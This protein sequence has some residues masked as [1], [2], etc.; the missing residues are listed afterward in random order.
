MGAEVAVPVDEHPDAL[1]ADVHNAQVLVSRGRLC[2]EGRQIAEG[3]LLRQGQLQLV[4]RPVEHGPVIL[5]GLFQGGAGEEPQ[6]GRLAGF[7]L[8]RALDRIVKV[9]AALLLV[10]VVLELEGQIVVQLGVGHRRHG[11][12]PAEHQAVRQDHR[13]VLL[14]GP[15]S[16][17]LLFQ[18]IRQRVHRQHRPSGHH[19]VRQLQRHR[20]LHAPPGKGNNLHLGFADI[21]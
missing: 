7:V 6:T 15:G 21:K 12:V 1:V 18:K 8:L 13:R 20:L 4:A 2:V 9:I 17:Q 3:R 14:D 5:N 10:Q 19:I 11:N 16:A